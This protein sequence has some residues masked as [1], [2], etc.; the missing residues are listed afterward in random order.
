MHSLIQREYV[1]KTA[2]G[3]IKRCYYNDIKSLGGNS[4]ET[5]ILV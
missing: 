5:D 1:A 2:C 4:Y 3:S